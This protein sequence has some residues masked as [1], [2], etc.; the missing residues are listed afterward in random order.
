MSWQA[1]V[2]VQMDLN[3]LS[4]LYHLSASFPPLVMCKLPWLIMELICELVWTLS[5]SELTFQSA[6]CLRMLRNLSRKVF[7]S[8]TAHSE[9]LFLSL[10]WMWLEEQKLGNTLQP[11]D[12]HSQG[13]DF[14]SSAETSSF[15]PYWYVRTQWVFSLKWVY[16]KDATHEACL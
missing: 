9:D 5:I 3:S 10:L 6:Y 13:S 2:G 15:S 8:V 4:S 12:P 14:M 7:P 16:N 1:I 11:A